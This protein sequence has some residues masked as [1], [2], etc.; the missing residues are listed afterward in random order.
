MTTS[1]FVEDI[2]INAM[3][4]RASRQNYFLI[5]SDFITAYFLFQAPKQI[6]RLLY[7]QRRIGIILNK[8]KNEQ[9]QQTNGCYI[10]KAFSMS[11]Y[12]NR[13]YSSVG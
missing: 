8:Q 7:L 5:N 12:N 3:L 2:K 11:I 10:D 6:G 1:C 13:S 9:A 4:F